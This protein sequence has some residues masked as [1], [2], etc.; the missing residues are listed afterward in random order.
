M[1]RVLVTGASGF[2]ASHLIPKLDEAGYD[3]WALLRFVAG[4]YRLGENVRSVF[5]DV[6]DYWAVKKAVKLVQPDIVVHL[7]ALS[8]VSYSYDH[9]QEVN[10]T[11]YIGT[12]NVAEACMKEL[13]HLE[14]M[15]YAGTSEEYGNQDSYPIR[16]DA[17][18]HPLSPYSVS[19]AASDMY[20]QYMMEAYDFPATIMR[21][22]NTYGRVKSTHFVTER[23]I[24]QMIRGETQVKLGDPTPIRDLVYRD[25]HV[26]AYMTVID[27]PGALYET[28]NFCT[29]VGVTI[30]EL[31]N[32]I[33]MLTDWTGD[34][35]WNTIPARPMDIRELVGD[36]SHAH[37]TL[38]WRP[39]YSLE[40]GLRKTINHLRENE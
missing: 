12:I 2:I 7:A 21:L 31:V 11:N 13:N 39:K 34:V 18:L 22:F 5:A 9:P 6:R 19:K 24:S 26:D 8:P 4:R 32:Q 37:R 3:V 25:D 1:K 28:F 30:K 17:K 36:Y 38:G 33:A 35:V 14:Q 23:I 29:G 10:E 20:L 15:V 27:N 16:E 40:Q